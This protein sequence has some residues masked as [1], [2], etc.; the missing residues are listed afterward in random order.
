MDHSLS[1][2][3]NFGVAANLFGNLGTKQLVASSCGLIGLTKE[4]KL[5]HFSYAISGEQKIVQYPNIDMVFDFLAVS[6]DGKSVA[7]LDSKQT[8]IVHW[9][10]HHDHVTLDQPY[11]IIRLRTNAGGEPFGV[12][13]MVAGNSHFMLLTESGEVFTWSFSS[14]AGTLT[15]NT[16]CETIPGIVSTLKGIKIVDIACGGSIQKG[17]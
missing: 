12:V 7:A 15:R 13:K 1:D 11:D 8:T 16:M 14:C 10:F 17:N 9:E 6:H 5:F 4:G 3:G 2:E